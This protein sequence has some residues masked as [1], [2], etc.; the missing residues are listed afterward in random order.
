MAA[1][2]LPDNVTI[3]AGTTDT[4]QAVMGDRN[5]GFQGFRDS[6]GNLVF[7]FQ[8]ASDT[9]KFFVSEDDGETWSEAD[10]VTFSD[11]SSTSYVSFAVHVET[12]Y[13]LF[14]GEYGSND[15]MSE[16]YQWDASAQTISAWIDEVAI[17][18][19][20]NGPQG[21]TSWIVGE[22]P[23]DTDM[24]YFFGHNVDDTTRSVLLVSFD[25]GTETLTDLAGSGNSVSDT[26]TKVA[27]AHTEGNDPYLVPD[28][29]TELL[30]LFGIDNSDESI[31]GVTEYQ[32]DSTNI[33]Q[34]TAFVDIDDRGSD[35]NTL[36]IAGGF[37]HPNE[38]RWYAWGAGV[39][40]SSS[41]ELFVYKSDSNDPMTATWSEVSDLQAD[42]G[43]YTMA[44]S[45]AVGFGMDALMVDGV[46]YFAIQHENSGD[47]DFAILEYDVEADSWTENEAGMTHSDFYSNPFNYSGGVFWPGAN[48][49]IIFATEMG[50]GVSETYVCVWTYSVGGGGGGGGATAVGWG[51]IPIGIS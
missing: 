16:M 49:D 51:F 23:N 3:P 19:D 37:Y 11:I 42:L 5:A 48:G 27:W 21:H 34:E 33:T 26:R 24:L 39:G 22:D 20:S 6:E 10:D 28:I 15:T 12:G 13:I 38:D 40:A 25:Q 43:T 36:Y 32:W 1:P 35:P 2:T 4:T 14:T 30:Y 44:G 45:I 8:D 50:P 47:F 18:S 7:L 17:Q 9:V 41:L 31:L 29:T 46:I